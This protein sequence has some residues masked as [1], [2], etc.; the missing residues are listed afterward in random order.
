MATSFKN[1]QLD[2]ITTKDL[3]DAMSQSSV[4]VTKLTGAN[5]IAYDKYVAAAK[6]ND[7]KLNPSA[8]TTVPPNLK[9]G[10]I[11]TKDLNA[12]M[13]ASNVNPDNF[14]PSQKI[15]YDKYS[16]AAKANDLKTS[17]IQTTPATSDSP[18]KNDSDPLKGFTPEPNATQSANAVSDLNRMPELNSLLLE[19]AKNG[20]RILQQ[21]ADE[22][23]KPLQETYDTMK[24]IYDTQDAEFQKKYDAQWSQLTEYENKTKE[25]IAELD[26]LGRKQ[27]KDYVNQVAR[28]ISGRKSA[29]AGD[30]SAQGFNTKVI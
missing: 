25:A 18:A 30:L 22:V 11:T 6:A 4:D 9:L 12:A 1:L 13:A 14:T 29:V 24:G 15:V 2:T 27:Y 28:T 26:V 19:E 8:V 21:K 23:N 17:P 20:V 10:N 16:A 7:A 3:N 5:K